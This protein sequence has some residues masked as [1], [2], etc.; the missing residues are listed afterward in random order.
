MTKLS[1]D[2]RVLVFS[3]QDQRRYYWY[4]LLTNTTTTPLWCPVTD[5]CRGG[6]RAGPVRRRFDVAGGARAG[7]GVAARPDPDRHRDRRTARTDL[8][9][10]PD[11][12]TPSYSM[13]GDGDWVFYICNV[14]MDGR[15]L[16]RVATTPGATPRRLG[17]TFAESTQ[18]AYVGSVSDDGT[19][20]GLMAGTDNGWSGA[21]SQH[22]MGLRRPDRRD[23]PTPVRQG[24]TWPELAEAQR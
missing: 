18:T 15:A 23:R 10:D 19:M 17:A 14:C 24:R 5:G 16:M 8:G 7:P 21:P 4:D 3:D 20:V 6:R 2:G 9:D 22:G 13:S 1:A 11:A 12:H